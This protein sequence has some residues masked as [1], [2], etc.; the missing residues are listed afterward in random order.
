[1]FCVNVSCYIPIT[2]SALWLAVQNPL[3]FFVIYNRKGFDRFSHF[4]QQQQQKRETNLSLLAEGSHHWKNSNGKSLDYECL[5][6]RYTWL[7]ET[8]D[9]V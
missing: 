4:L 2:W 1:M 7:T 6:A 3:S 5:Y 9:F 8:A